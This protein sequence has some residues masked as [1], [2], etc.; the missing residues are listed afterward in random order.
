MY[1]YLSQND[2]LAFINVDDP[3]QVEKS[4]LLK[5]YSFGLNREDADVNINSVRANPFVEVECAT[6]II[7]SHLIGLYNAN[8]LNAA[9]T[10]GKYFGV[11]DLEIKEALESYI[12]AA[13]WL[14]H[15]ALLSN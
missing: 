8:N 10:I 12:K 1:I 15:D 4:K 2:K 5:Y 13:Q 9:L 6:S 11:K 7:T 14:A 3:I